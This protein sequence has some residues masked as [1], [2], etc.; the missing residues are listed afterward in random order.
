MK[1]STAAEIKK[2]PVGDHFDEKVTGLCVRV[3][4]S[5]HRSWSL[6]FRVNGRLRRWTI[7]PYPDVSLVEARERARDALAEVRK[8]GDPAARKKADREAETFGELAARYIKEYAKPRKRKWKG[9]EQTL[10]RHVL[11]LWKNVPVRKIRRADVKALLK[12]MP[13]E[14]FPNRVRALLSKVFNFA[15]DEDIVEV[16]PVLGTPRRPERSR[17]RVLIDEEI[18]QVWES[19]DAVA[20]LRLVTAQRGGEVLNMRRSEIDADWWTIPAER[21]KNKLAHRVPLSELALEVLGS[22]PRLEGRDRLF[23]VR[24]KP[25]GI[26][27][28][29][30]HDLRRTAASRMASLGVPRVVIG[31]VL[32]HAEPG[33]TAVYDRHSY[34]AEKRHALNRWA[35]ELRRIVEGKLAD[36]V[37]FEA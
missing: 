8:G 25:I 34:D 36:V 15:R 31:K 3:R 10:R 28:I 29:R 17:D 21:S 12:E 22:V 26:D 23:P 24:P 16:N 13:G 11:P 20:K 32:N 27:D 35:R 14:V 18:R 1:F 5:G 7:G 19:G 33:V 37:K 6:M 4:E 30:G 2:L 9:D